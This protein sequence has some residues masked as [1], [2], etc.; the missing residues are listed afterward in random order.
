MLI[1]PIINYYISYLPCVPIATHEEIIMGTH[2]S[3]ISHNITMRP[4]K[5]RFFKIVSIFTI[6]DGTRHKSYIF[7][8]Y[9]ILMGL[10]GIMGFCSVINGF[11]LP[12]NKTS[13]VLMGVSIIGVES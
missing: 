7:I 11:Q 9:L 4:M 8:I 12:L 5:T 3:L 2:N 6:E 1:A 13:W 10:M